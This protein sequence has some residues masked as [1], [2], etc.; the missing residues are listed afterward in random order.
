L[1]WFDSK[2]NQVKQLQT[3]SNPFQKSLSV[4]QLVEMKKQQVVFSLVWKT[5]FF[6]KV[7]IQIRSRFK[8]GVDYTLI[9]LEPT[10]TSSNSSLPSNTMDLE[11]SKLKIIL[12]QQ[13]F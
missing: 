2:V 5:L 8:E 3:I 7:L 10:H 12:D 6:K 4:K 13:F 1:N 9:Y 11:T